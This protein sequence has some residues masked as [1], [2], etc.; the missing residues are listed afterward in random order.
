MAERSEPAGQ[1]I[2]SVHERA[3]ASGR[4]SS[5]VLHRQRDLI[6][7]AKLGINKNLEL[8]PS[9]GELA[10]TLGCSPSYLS[11]TFHRIAGLSLRRYVAQLRAHIAAERLAAGASDLTELALDLGYADHSHFTNSF[12]KEWGLSPSRFRS[13]TAIHR[14]EQQT[15]GR[16]PAG[17]DSRASKQ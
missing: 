12:R 1:T 3:R 15:P 7:K 2:H 4:K 10:R 16:G 14:P 5:D 11:R 9:L 8:R 6:E 17:P 13:R